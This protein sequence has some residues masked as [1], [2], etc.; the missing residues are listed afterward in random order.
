ML[1]LCFAINY[2]KS[3][4]QKEN[5]VHFISSFKGLL[6]VYMHDFKNQCWHSKL[7]SISNFSYLEIVV[8][9]IRSSLC[10]VSHITKPSYNSVTW[11]FSFRWYLCLTLLPMDEAISNYCTYGILCLVAECLVLQENAKILSFPLAN[12]YVYI[13][14]FPYNFFF[15]FKIHSVT[16]V[17]KII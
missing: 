5:C 14:C 2:V 17:N 3:I 11:F 10:T 6:N 8:F 16:L 1:W 15:L 12:L 7:F 13:F 4:F 9:K